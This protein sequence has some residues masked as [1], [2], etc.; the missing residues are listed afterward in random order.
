MTT[1]GDGDDAT[2][3]DMTSVLADWPYP[4]PGGWTAD[5]LDLLPSDGPNGELDFFKHVELVD[6]ALIFM[7]PQKRFHERVL[8]GLR[9]ILNAQLPE[10]VV[11]VGQMDVKLGQRQRPC[12]DV[13]LVD[14]SAAEDDGRTYYLPEE[15]CLVVEV[16]SPESEY[17]DREVKPQRYAAAGIPHFWRVEN[18]DNRPVVY[19]YELDPAT[20]T[21]AVTG[22]Y[23]SRLAVEVPFPIEIDLDG[24]PR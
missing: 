21:Y 13:S 3:R 10:K 9:T 23:H 17:R 15:I 11:A 12:P 5:D 2:L 8:Y 16:V 19:V 6:G 4:P 1:N 14:S 22:I 18:N 20:R 24:L 7:S